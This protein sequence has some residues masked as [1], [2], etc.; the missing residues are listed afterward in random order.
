MA[1][2]LAQASVFARS[3][4]SCA[5]DGIR[6]SSGTTAR[7][8]NSR[9]PMML[10]PCGLSSSSRSV[11]IFETIAVDDI[12]SAPPSANAACQLIRIDGGSRFWISQPNSTVAAMVS[13]T[14]AIPSP[15]TM[16]R[17]AIRC[18]SENSRPIENIRN[19]TPNSASAWV[20]LLF[21]AMPSACGPIRMPTAR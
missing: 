13:S 15:N 21:S 16:R 5:S 11:S 18:D 7:S 6:I 4:G 8:W 14:C 9:M 12:A 19:T 10:R 20:V 17:I 3:A 1:L 2:T